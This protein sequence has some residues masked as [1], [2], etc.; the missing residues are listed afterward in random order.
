MNRRFQLIKC[1]GIGKKAFSPQIVGREIRV[2]PAWHR[3]MELRQV[4]NLPQQQKAEAGKR[5]VVGGGFHI[6]YWKNATK[7]HTASGIR[8]LLLQPIFR[9]GEAKRRLSSHSR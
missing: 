8:L 3:C 7:Y 5:D 2:R 4:L 9:T 1:C 6:Y